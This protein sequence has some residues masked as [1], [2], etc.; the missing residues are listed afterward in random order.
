MMNR[1]HYI[2]VDYENIHEVE[3]D[4]IAD[5]PVTVI[6]VLGERH[7][8]LPVDLVKKLL[9]YPTQVRLVEAGRSGKNALDFVLSYLIGV[10]T[11]TDRTG[12]FHILSRDKGFDALIEHLKKNDIFA[13][14]HE[15]FARIP[16]LLGSTAAARPATAAPRKAVGER[17]PR[18]E[19]KSPSAPA[20]PDRVKETVDWFAHHIANRPKTRTKLLSHLHTHFGKRM[21]TA[22]LDAIVSELTTRDSIEITPPRPGSLQNL[23]A[24]R[25]ILRPFCTF[26]SQRYPSRSRNQIP[27]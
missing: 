15:I 11:M 23:V 21:S 17:A 9:R 25:Q 13:D 20:A 12:H 22:E 8:K 6:L 18:R 5:Q 26:S 24:V 7:K 19:R 27:M 16:A 2:F 10:Q 3:L 14:R 1:I 4:L